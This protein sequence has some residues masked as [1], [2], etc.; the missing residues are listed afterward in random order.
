MNVTEYE[1]EMLC[2][3][4]NWSRLSMQ[5]LEESFIIKY[6]DKLQLSDAVSRTRLSV[7]ALKTLENKLGDAWDTIAITYPDYEELLNVFGDSRLRWSM[8]S[9]NRYLSEDFIRK[10]KDSI[11]FH[12]LN[13]QK[14]YSDEFL[15]EFKDQLDWDTL[16]LL[17]WMDVSLIE[18]YEDYINWKLIVATSAVTGELLTKHIHDFEYVD[19]SSAN[20]KQLTSHAL[21][22][23]NDENRFLRGTELA[24]CGE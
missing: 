3:F 12:K 1:I 2:K 6:A 5:S 9:R 4:N 8:L 17:S 13:P 24:L 10:H 16:S 22:V 20:R 23:L 15:W 11:V 18:K 19:L 14:V 7:D 21:T